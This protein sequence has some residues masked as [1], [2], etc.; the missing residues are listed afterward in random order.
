MANS[1]YQRDIKKTTRAAK[2]THTAHYTRVPVRGGQRQKIAT[3]INIFCAIVVAS[4]RCFP[5]TSMPIFI[6]CASCRERARAPPPKCLL[7]APALSPP[8]SLAASLSHSFIDRLSCDKRLRNMCKMCRLRLG[9][10]HLMAY[11]A[12]DKKGKHNQPTEIIA[13][14]WRETQQKCA[15]ISDGLVSGGNN[16][17]ARY[18]TPLWQSKR[19]HTRGSRCEVSAATTTANIAIV[20]T[21]WAL[22]APSARSKLK[23]ETHAASDCDKKPRIGEDYE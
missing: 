9:R 23:R 22:N 21:D 2:T 16:N 4:V 3:I 5:L 15:Q 10:T 13:T 11:A 18:C 7:T 12:I 19:A 20:T 14:A 1:I 17:C 6:E 8:A